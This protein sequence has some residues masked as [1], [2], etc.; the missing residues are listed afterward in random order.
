M[1]V[2]VLLSGGV[3]SSVALRQVQSLG[4]VSITA[5]YLKIWLEDEV[6]Y[7]GN[8]P[9]EDDLAYAR[10]VCNQAGVPLE[11]VPLQTEYYQKVVEYALAELRLGRTPSPD[12]FC[13]QR[14]KFG[15]FF[16]KV[17]NEFDGV[18]S[19]HYAWTS[20]NPFNPQDTLTRLY[21]APDPVKDQS[22]FLSHLSQEQVAKL[23]FP[24][25]NMHKSEVRTLARNW[26]LPNKDRKDSQGICFLGNIK[27]PDF[28][29]HYLGEK[30]GKILDLETRKV[31]GSH[32]G[33]W[34]HTIGQR[35]GLGLGNG[36]WYVVKKVPEE[37]LVLVSHQDHLPSH[38]RSTFVIAELTWIAGTNPLTRL[39]KTIEDIDDL[40]RDLFVKLRHGPDLV[41]ARA[42]WSNG[43]SP[44]DDPDP[45]LEISLDKP[46]QGLAPGQF[47][48][49]YRNTECLGSGKIQE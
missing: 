35:S 38:L 26:D 34:F 1:N 6:S 10:G 9:W 37:N 32:K 40:N 33:F 13:N 42:R 46:D 43:A 3:D 23:Y 21:R 25:G 12:I 27:Y 7:L 22:Y 29:R 20:P 45:R 8:C 41:P 17:G 36:P 19:G 47:G 18:V 24:L 49:L 14:I 11:V 15:S 5:F 48:V 28:V 2:A 16:D 39:P 30:E 4:G 44:T 31:L